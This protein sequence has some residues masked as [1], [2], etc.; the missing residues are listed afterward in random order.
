[1]TAIATQ[2]GTR[3]NKWVKR[4]TIG[5]YAGAT[6]LVYN[7]SGSQKTMMGNKDASSAVKYYFQEPFVTKRVRIYPVV[8]TFPVCLRMELYGC[9][10]NPDCILVGSEVWGFWRFN[11][12]SFNYF[13]ANI[14]KLNATHVDFALQ[15]N[16]DQTRSY[17]RNDPVLVVDRIPKIKDISVNSQVI[18]VHKPGRNEW[19]RNG[20]VTGTDGS[21]FVSVKFHDGQQ[22]HGIPLNELRLVNRPRVCVDRV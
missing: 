2:G 15:V 1:V 14:I 19:Y 8:D 11:I 12:D 17:K 22:R 21:S 13:K 4:Y 6:L 18:A 7:K 20:T 3:L 16:K 9:D 5:F 10:P